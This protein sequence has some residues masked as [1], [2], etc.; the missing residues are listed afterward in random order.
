MLKEK[1]SVMVEHLYRCTYFRM[2]VNKPSVIAILLLRQGGRCM[3]CPSGR[4]WWMA[5][6]AYCE[7]R[8]HYRHRWPR[9]RRTGWTV[10]GAM[11]MNRSRS[12]PD[13]LDMCVRSKQA[14]NQRK[15]W[16]ITGIKSWN[17]LKISVFRKNM[18]ARN[19]WFIL[20]HQAA[21]S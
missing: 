16:L 8:V 14:E 5:W 2:L 19:S 18:S 20:V 6:I 1:V 10:C 3:R 21:F 17:L 12:G 7:A 15:D 11:C 9:V 13:P 4:T